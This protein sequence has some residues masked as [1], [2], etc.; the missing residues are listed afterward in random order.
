MTIDEWVKKYEGKSVGYP[1]GSY[2]GQCLSLAKWFIKDIYKINPPASGCNGARCY[3]SIFPSPLG[4]VLKKVPNTPTLVP[5]KGWI[6]VWN[7]KVGDGY[8]HISVVLS[9]NVNT[10]VSLDQ[11]WYSKL[12]TKVTHNYTNVY[13]FLAPLETTNNNMQELL[14]KYSVKTIEELDK[15]I[16]EHLG[17]D[18]GNAENANN[19][20]HLASDRRKIIK[21]ENEAI[22]RENKITNLEGQVAVLKMEKAKVTQDLKDA[23]ARRVLVEGE[24]KE[25]QDEIKR[26]NELIKSDT[27][28]LEKIIAE[29]E[30]QISE[31]EGEVKRLENTKI[32]QSELVSKFLEQVIQGLGNYG[33]EKTLEGV[34]NSI[35]QREAQREELKNRVAELE[36]NPLIKI[37]QALKDLI[38]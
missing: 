32:N 20:S 12:A 38:R 5:Q 22:A 17:L 19:K 13:G 2:V 36:A 8:G 14:N 6:A 25:A 37:F 3:W 18:W 7:E 35:S 21:L 28:T 26:L 15:K 23:N 30:K 9:A 10:F 31:L 1:E 4:T 24:L 33:G 11:N 16:F 27:K 29:R 34:L